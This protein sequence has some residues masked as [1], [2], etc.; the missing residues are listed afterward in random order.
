MPIEYCEY[1]GKYEKCQQWLE[2]NLPQL[3]AQKL[4][5]GEDEGQEAAEK[6]HQVKMIQLNKENT[7]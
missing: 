1:S 7:K 3:A 2:K 5:L 4:Q 6:K